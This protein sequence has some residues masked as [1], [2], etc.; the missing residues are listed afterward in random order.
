MR[1]DIK[2]LTARIFSILIGLSLSFMVIIVFTNAVLRYAFNSGIPAGEEL[3]RYFFIW[4]TALGTVI[5]FN[6]KRHVGVDLL[7]GALKGKPKL[8]VVNIGRLITL[9]CFMLVLWG[10]IQYFKTSAA[11]PGPATGIPFGYVSFSIIV[12]A[13]SIIV[14]TIR[15]FIRDLRAAPEER[16]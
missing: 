13:G 8:I 6:E 11:S 7:V 10:G 16:V 15:D 2:G 4:I 12:V 14:L 5:A 3:S 9:L 1:N